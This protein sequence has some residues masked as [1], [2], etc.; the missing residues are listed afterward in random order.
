MDLASLNAR[1]ADDVIAQD[2]PRV[3]PNGRISHWVSQP[4]FRGTWDILWTCLITIFIC[5]YTL[6]CLNV[7]APK[8]S[9][10]SLV[11][12]RILWIFLAIVAPEV[13]LTYASGQWSRAQQSVEAF[14]AAGFNNW[15]M[16]LAFFAD[17]GGFVLHARDSESFPLNAKQLY[18]LVE[19]RQIEY[20][21]VK[22]EEIWDKS[23]QDRLSKVIASVQIGYFVLQ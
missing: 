14:K 16:R 18:W 10:I 5:T 4:G 3:S 19:H 22:T 7:P 13:V 21:E 12:R 1:I 23:K 17:M 15:R 11:R 9:L 20:P 6:L 2:F 8:D